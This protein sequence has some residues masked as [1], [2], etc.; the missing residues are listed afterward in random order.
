M[1]NVSAYPL[2]ASSL[3]HQKAALNDGSFN[4]YWAAVCV[5]EDYS[6]KKLAE[7]GGFN[8]DLRTEA[9]GYKLLGRLEQFI[10]SKRHVKAK[11]DVNGMSAAEDSVR[12]TL[13][14]YGVKVS[15][16]DGIGDYWKAAEI[17][18]SGKITAP[19]RNSG[20]QDDIDTLRFQISQISKKQRKVARQNIASLPSEWRAA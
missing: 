4:A 19:S 8:F 14:A 18:W 10:R 3:R 12:A 20:R 9:N 1:L 13:G 5:A 7:F 6:D 16:L 15:K 2:C 11:S 17:L